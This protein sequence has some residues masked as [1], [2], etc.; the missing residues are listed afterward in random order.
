MAHLICDI[1]HPSSLWKYLALFSLFNNSNLKVY[2][3]LNFSF[4]PSSCRMFLS[5]GQFCYCHFS[6]QQNFYNSSSL[7]LMATQL[8]TLLH[9]I[10]CLT[11]MSFK[12]SIT[13]LCYL[14]N[15]NS[16]YNIPLKAPPVFMRMENKALGDMSKDKYS[17]Q[18][19]L[20]LYLSFNMPARCI[21]HT[22]P[23]Q[24]FK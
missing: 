1:A 14:F 9:A 23:Q 5:I 10:T 8:K 17:N 7:H 2:A 15:S 3:G 18:L 16:Q 21:F 13:Q 4:Y 11:C 19:Y 20:M 12:E 22:Y 6:P 24:C